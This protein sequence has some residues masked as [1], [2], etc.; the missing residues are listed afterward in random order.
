MQYYVLQALFSKVTNGLICF[1]YLFIYNV[2]S[3]FTSYYYDV[4]SGHLNC[5]S[6]VDILSEFYA[7]VAH[8]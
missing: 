8:T 3:S 4:V 7:L 1:I 5:P 2:G 6:D